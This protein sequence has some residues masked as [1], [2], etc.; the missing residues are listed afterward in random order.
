M[1]KETISHQ[2]T[3]DLHIDAFVCLADAGDGWRRSLAVGGGA[4]VVWGVQKALLRPPDVWQATQQICASSPASPHSCHVSV[5]VSVRLSAHQAQAQ[6]QTHLWAV[7]GSGHV[8]LLSDAWVGVGEAGPGRVVHWGG[9]LLVPVRE[10]C[11]RVLCRQKQ[12][13]TCCDVYVVRKWRNHTNNFISFQNE[14][15]FNFIKYIT[16]KF[17]NILSVFNI[18]AV[19]SHL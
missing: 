11:G 15:G 5:P 17:H 3:T 7:E 10:S 8:A 14:I 18:S 4:R 16:E 6:A 1:Q 13:T 2:T 12:R 19:S 9:G